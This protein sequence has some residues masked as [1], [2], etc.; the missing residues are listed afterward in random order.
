M[1][2]YCGRVEPLEMKAKRSLSFSER[3]GSIPLSPLLNTHQATGMRSNFLAWDSLNISFLLKT[4]SFAL[5]PQTW[6]PRASQCTDHTSHCQRGSPSDTILA[7]LFF[8][9]HDQI[10]FFLFC[11][12]PLTE[13]F[14]WKTQ[15]PF[16]FPEIVPVAQ[17]VFYVPVTQ[18]VPYTWS[19]LY[20]NVAVFTF[21]AGFQRKF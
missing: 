18:W 9:Y 13:N 20:W 2:H 8:V 1:H 11:N 19:P 3:E 14:P 10:N 5:L 21:L 6:P 7:M 15:G 16:C 17:W 4:D 12:F